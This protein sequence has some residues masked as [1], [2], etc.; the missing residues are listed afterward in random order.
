MFDGALI[1]SKHCKNHFQ[2]NYGAQFREQLPSFCSN[3]LESSVT[4]MDQNGGG[5]AG[6]GGPGRGRLETGVSEIGS[7]AE[8]FAPVLET[9]V[10][11]TGSSAE[12]FA[13]VLE[14]GVSETGSSAETFAPVLETR[15]SETGSSAET[16]APVLESQD[17][18]K[19]DESGKRKHSENSWYDCCAL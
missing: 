17:D 12:T 6:R 19:K 14:T 3:L 5:G 15:V 13:P 1:T 2:I 9:G 10:S 11:E 7:S 8:T 16:F 18:A 4:D